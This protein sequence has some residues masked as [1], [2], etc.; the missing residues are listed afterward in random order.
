MTEQNNAQV[1][2][3]TFADRATADQAIRALQDAGFG[4]D[5]INGGQGPL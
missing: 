5:H 2:V 1:A 3:K 4:S